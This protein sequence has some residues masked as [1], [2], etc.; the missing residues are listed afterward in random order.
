KSNIW[1]SGNGPNSVFIDMSGQKEGRSDFL[2]LIASST[3][4]CRS[5]AQQAGNL[6][7]A[8]ISFDEEDPE[9]I[10]F[11]EKGLRLDNDS[12]ILPCRA[13][14]SQME[15]ISVRLS[16]LPLLSESKLLSGLKES[17]SPFGRI[18]DVGLLLEPEH[19]TFMG[20]GFAI[21]DVSKKTRLLVL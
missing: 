8:E 17:L 12:I 5:C 21:L 20:N 13:L 3:F 4:S 2:R 7:F 9:V 1:R 6:R 19:K 11:L 18:L 15:I 10:T 16:K 14:E